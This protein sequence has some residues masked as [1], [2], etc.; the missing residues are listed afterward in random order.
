MTIMAGSMTAW[1]AAIA[2]RQ[3]LSVSISSASWRQRKRKTGLS[4]VFGNLKSTLS[5]TPPP[6]R[7][8]LLILPKIVLPTRD[9]AFKYMSQQGMLLYSTTVGLM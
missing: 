1:Q 5:D 9:E 4:L 6:T 3:Q 8:F 7:A 2:P